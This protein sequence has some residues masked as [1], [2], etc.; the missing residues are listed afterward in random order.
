VINY[1]FLVALSLV[2]VGGA[3]FDGHFIISLALAG[4]GGLIMSLIFAVQSRLLNQATAPRHD[5]GRD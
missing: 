3:F 1:L 5:G 2:Y 4:G